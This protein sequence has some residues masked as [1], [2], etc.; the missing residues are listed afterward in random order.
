MHTFWLTHKPFPHT[1]MLTHK[2]CILARWDTKTGALTHTHTHKLSWHKHKNAVKC[3][4][5]RWTPIAWLEY[6][7]ETY[8]IFVSFAYAHLC[9]MTQC[10]N[11]NIWAMPGPVCSW[12]VKKCTQ[13]L[14]SSPMECI[15][16][17][18]IVVAFYVT[19]CQ[20]YLNYYDDYVLV[21]KFNVD[22]SVSLKNILVSSLS[23]TTDVYVLTWYKV[24]LT[25]E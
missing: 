7:V 8:F 6:F 13:S 3:S 20:S 12:L 4:T 15:I 23:L 14:E 5:W 19:T 11:H 24:L 1:C 22:C 9:S 17:L 25:F 21:K 18:V 2:E 10:L 16:R